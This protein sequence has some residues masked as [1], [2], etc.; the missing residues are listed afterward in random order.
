MIKQQHLEVAVERLNDELGRPEAGLGHIAL[1]GAYGGWRLVE[2]TAI[3]PL[4]LTGAYI[5]KRDLFFQ[6]STARTL[7]RN[8]AG[9]V[10]FQ[11]S[12]DESTVFRF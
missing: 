12:G 11:A 7:L 5:P 1:D 9:F 8:Q 10:Q 2:T 4:D 3:G 6:V